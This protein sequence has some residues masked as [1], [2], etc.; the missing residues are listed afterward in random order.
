MKSLVSICDRLV[1]DSRL[2]TLDCL[3]PL[4]DLAGA[5]AR[6]QPVLGDMNWT[7]LDA[8]REALAAIF[9]DGSRT[10][11]LEGLSRIEVI[12]TRSPRRRPAAA[13]LL[14]AGWLAS[15]VGC[16]RP[17]PISGG[18]SMQIDSSGRRAD[19][20]FVGGGP[21]RPSRDTVVPLHGFKLQALRGRRMFEAEMLLEHGEGHLRERET[22]G[23]MHRR[24]VPVPLL[25]E[26][27]VLS[28]ELARMGR[29]RVFEDALLSAARIRSALG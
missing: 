17:Q 12:G 8:F 4:S 5:A 19:F 2:G 21:V 14:F 11:Y 23:H 24:P 20:V 13:E 22:P 15:R 1:I 29:D 18:V 3:G 6:A 7:R 27:E 28:R 9:D 26:A 16:S 25:G 10:R